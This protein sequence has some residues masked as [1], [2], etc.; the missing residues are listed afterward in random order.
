MFITPTSADTKF[1]ITIGFG[2]YW[3][4]NYNKLIWNSIIIIIYKLKYWDFLL[5][6]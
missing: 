2:L 1:N 6:F 4:Q 3:N 5:I